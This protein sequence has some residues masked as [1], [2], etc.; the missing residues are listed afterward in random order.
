MTFTDSV[1][2]CSTIYQY[3]TNHKVVCQP[4]G[5]DTQKSRLNPEI[6]IFQFRVMVIFMLCGQKFE[7][8]KLSVEQSGMEDNSPMSL[9][10]F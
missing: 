8:N 7:I 6:T 2:N 9:N 3:Y 1:L 10:L 4:G 5:I